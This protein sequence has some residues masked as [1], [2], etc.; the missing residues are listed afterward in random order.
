[1]ARRKFSEVER[2]LMK[3]I[4]ENLRQIIEKRGWS[5]KDL[6]DKAGLS[7]SV[8]SDYLNE[9]TL[10]TPGSLQMM[11]DALNIPKGDIDPSFRDLVR[12]SSV[13]YN[14]SRE[15][16][17]LPIEDLIKR[18]LTYKGHKLTEDQ[19]AQFAKLVQAAADMLQQ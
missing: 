18:Q 16:S 17:D 11:S 15:L 2:N 9:K 14:T 13:V 3:G 19:K 5:Q 7:T 10:A 4:A 8:I 1:M 12:E 6:A